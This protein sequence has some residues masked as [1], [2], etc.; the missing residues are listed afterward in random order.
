MKKQILGVCEPSAVQE[1]HLWSVWGGGWVWIVITWSVDP[2]NVILRVLEW[3]FF[4]W[5][6][7]AF[8]NFMS[9]HYG[10]DSVRTGFN[11]VWILFFF[12]LLILDV[13]TISCT[14]LHGDHCQQSDLDVL[15]KWVGGGGD[16]SYAHTLFSWDLRSR[17]LVKRGWFSIRCGGSAFRFPLAWL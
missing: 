5:Y 11:K 13:F 16:L 8:S 7:L 10:G 14:I 3:C 9:H 15:L 17:L 2:I 4:F 6:T 1:H 12:L